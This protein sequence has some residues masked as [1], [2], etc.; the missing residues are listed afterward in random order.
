M[1]SIKRVALTAALLAVGVGA[2]AKPAGYE[3][4][5]G[6]SQGKV[7]DVFAGGVPNQNVALG[8]FKQQFKFEDWRFDRDSEGTF[9]TNGQVKNAKFDLFGVEGSQGISEIV[10]DLKEASELGSTCAFGACAQGGPFANVGGG[11]SNTPT[12]LPEPGMWAVLL[13]ALS[14]MLFGA[15]LRRSRV[16]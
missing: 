8:Q 7:G 12:P 3:I 6:A 15:R 9:T 11:A 4:A 16:R 13:A 1:M 10:K 2:Q 14:A 5:L